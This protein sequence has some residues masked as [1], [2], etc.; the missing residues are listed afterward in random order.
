VA[1]WV[2]VL[3]A[4]E[5][6]VERLFANPSLAAREIPVGD[7]VV[8]A[9]VV[10]DRPV[11]FGLGRVREAGEVTYT[12][13]LF[14]EPVADGSLPVGTG[15]SRL[16]AGAYAAVAARIGA[17]HRTDADKRTWLV[18]VDLPIEARSPA[19][20][21]REFW[22]YVTRLGPRELPAYVAPTEDELAMQAYVLGEEANLDPEED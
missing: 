5:Y 15:A 9:T 19:E 8:L 6:E 13:R 16:D 17:E 14:D 4:A 2:F 18:S 20:A 3:P 7:E 22:T 21:V 1:Y 12:H 10:E 11:V